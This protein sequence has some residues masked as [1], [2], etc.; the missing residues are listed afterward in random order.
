MRFLIQLGA[1]E[2]L[3]VAL[4]LS[5]FFPGMFEGQTEYC[6]SGEIILDV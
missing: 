2:I 1:T 5:I 6:P 3:K 4:N